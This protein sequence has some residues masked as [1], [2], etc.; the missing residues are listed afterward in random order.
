[1]NAGTSSTTEPAT[2]NVSSL[3]GQQ[4]P[5]DVSQSTTTHPNTTENITQKP[6]QS[7]KPSSASTNPTAPPETKTSTN[8]QEVTSTSATNAGTQQENAGGLAQRL[9]AQQTKGVKKSGLPPWHEFTGNKG[10]PHVCGWAIRVHQVS[11]GDT[12]RL[13]IKDQKNQPTIITITLDGIRAPRVSRKQDSQDEPFGFEAREFV[14][15]T[16]M[17]KPVFYAAWKPA[18]ENDK[19]YYGDLYVQTAPNKRISLTHDVVSAGWAELMAKGANT[20]SEKEF[21]ALE[22]AAQQ[23]KA[24]GLGRYAVSNDNKNELKKH[25]RQVEWVKKNHSDLCEKF[26]NKEV[27]AIVDQALSGSTLRIEL[28]PKDSK[29]KMVNVNLAGCN[30]PRLPR[31]DDTDASNNQSSKTDQLAFE[32]QRFA[33]ERLLGQEVK[34]KMLLCDKYDNIYATI[35]HPNGRIAASLLKNGLATYDSWTAGQ[36]D[37]AEQRALIA[38][39]NEAKEKRLGM[40]KNK[41]PKSANITGEDFI[42]G[43]VTQVISSYTVA[44]KLKNGK[45]ERFTLSSIRAPRSEKETNENKG[46]KETKETKKEDKKTKQDYKEKKTEEDELLAHEAKEFL[47]RKTIGQEVHVYKEYTRDATNESSGKERSFATIYIASTKENV[48]LALVRTELAEV[49][50]HRQGEPR[51][52]EYDKLDTAEKEAKKKTNTKSREKNNRWKI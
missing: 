44:I 45:E 32:S 21:K 17:N 26:K 18:K 51:S 42:S 38:A 46:K 4:Q 13:S 10:D 7:T 15:K 11:S 47:R 31:R 50:M 2:S 30:A 35:I 14:R 49:V 27:D 9:N 28:L 40:W 39:A 36:C 29:H 22:A 33:E 43:T 52:R 20:L 12:L 19:H 16:V 37:E 1:V 3:Q 24:S 41:D 48:A 8:E 5:S 25:T 23:A 34:V 6:T